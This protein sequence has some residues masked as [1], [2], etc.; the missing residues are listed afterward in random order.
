MNTK[1]DS[2]STNVSYPYE[3]LYSS[4]FEIADNSNT[5]TLMKIWKAWESGNLS[6]AKD[7]FADSL[8]MHTADGHILK[9]PRDSVMKNALDYRS[10]LTSVT[11]TVDAVLS[12]RSKDKDENW[13]S[14]WG[15]EISTNTKG[16]TDSIYLHE[17]WR[18]N[19]QGKVNFMLQYLRPAKPAL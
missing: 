13:V 7:H 6:D 14:I 16:V 1:N 4:Q 19:K 2:A 3:I 5:Q 18:F 12:S 9:G 8:E 15:K 10:T 17:T 11:S